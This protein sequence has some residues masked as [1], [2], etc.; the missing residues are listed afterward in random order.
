MQRSAWKWIAIALL[1]MGLY[2]CDDE[3]VGEPCI[4]ER[5]PCDPTEV[6]HP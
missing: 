3:G 1:G 6:S 2:G 4:P 5:I